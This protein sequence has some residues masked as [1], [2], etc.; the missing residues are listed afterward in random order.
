DEARSS[1]QAALRLQGDN[2]EAKRILDQANR[3][4]APS[5]VETAEPVRFTRQDSI[6]FRLDNFASEK[7]YLISTMIGGV[8]VFDFDNDGLLDIF[9]ANGAEIPS[10]KKT[11]ARFW[12]R[13]YRNLGGWR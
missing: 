9:F 6:D 8:A 12:N 3:A 13:L 4:P 10:L 2:E 11:G 5:T 1:A 7:K